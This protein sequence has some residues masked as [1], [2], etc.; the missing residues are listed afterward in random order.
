MK[1]SSKI[2]TLLLICAMLLISTAAFAVANKLSDRASRLPMLFGATY[3]TMNNPFFEVLN[4]SIADVVESNGDILISRD[5]ARD[6]Q[7]QNAQIQEMIDEGI[8][9]LFLNPVDWKGVL[10]A[11]EMCRKAGVAVINIDTLVYDTD[12]VVSI[13]ESDNYG[14]G[15]LCAEDLMS[16][17]NHARIIVLDS[18][19]TASITQRVNGFLDTIAPY[20]QYE[21]VYTEACHGELEIALDVMNRILLEQNLDFDVVFGGNDPTAIG[22][23]AA[24]QQSRLSG[25]VLIYGIDGS[26]DFM[27]ML[28]EG[29]ATATSVQSPKTIGTVAAETAYQYLSGEDVTEYIQIPVTLLTRENLS[30]IVMIDWQ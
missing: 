7:K 12:Y 17:R 27:V 28:K 29:L 19:I 13:I 9:I 22:A 26:P 25:G 6:Q 21:V 1:V 4:D 14:A 10:P 3:M 18:P 24:L 5:P 16:K 2:I 15:V 23:L 20:P 30:E 8:K 11:L